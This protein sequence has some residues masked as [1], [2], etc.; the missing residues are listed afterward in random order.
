[1]GLVPAAGAVLG[2]ELSGSDTCTDDASTA[3]RVVEPQW[4]VS[5]VI[6]P[7]GETT[8]YGLTLSVVM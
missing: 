6:D 7:I 5:P 8:N 3:H 4:F 2:F 1:M